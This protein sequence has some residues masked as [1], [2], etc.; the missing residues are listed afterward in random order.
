MTSPVRIQS[1]LQKPNRCEAVTHVYAL[2][3]RNFSAK[4][5]VLLSVAPIAVSLCKDAM[6]NLFRL[7]PRGAS[8]VLCSFLLFHST[9]ASGFASDQHLLHLVP[10]KSKIVARMLSSSIP[11]QLSSFLLVTSNNEIDHK[12]FLALTGGD[13]SRNIHEVVFVT[14]DGA[15]GANSE[16]S[17]LVGGH[18][19]RDAI[20]RLANDGI[21]TR[22]NY[23]DVV[24]LAV[25][26]FAREAESFKE[27]RW[28]AIPD[29]GIA[30]FGSVASV[31]RELDRWFANS[32]T[33]PELL[34]RLSRLDHR[35]ETW[36]LLPVPRPG[37]LVAS[38]FGK[39]DERLE[40]LAN[41][42]R[43]IQYGIRFG[44]NVEITASN[45]P[46]TQTSWSTRSDPRG[47]DPIAWSYFLSGSNEAIVS[48]TVHVKI[49][50]KT[51]EKWLAS[52]SR[53]SPFIDRE[54]FS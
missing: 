35:D 8:F 33:D 36:C 54:P 1:L 52:F 25:K 7:L 31:Q 34:E 11:G 26:P 24:V 51:Y 20:V 47:T 32:P 48:R 53:G 23:R 29:Q 9:S 40:A 12:D 22:L 37:G 45:N 13:S 10:P 39:L 3:F 6:Q 27:L 38:I 30:I 43:S 5:C 49:P 19:D 14:A 21:A 4:P 41:E 28:L 15:D 18:F 50:R 46:T 42:G 16:H 17:L 2:R 44:R